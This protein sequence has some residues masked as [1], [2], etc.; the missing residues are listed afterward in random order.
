MTKMNAKI[1][2]KKSN[3][4]L[5]SVFCTGKCWETVSAFMNYQDCSE[6]NLRT[7]SGAGDHMLE[8]GVGR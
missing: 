5:R 1:E 3:Y 4:E 8:Q 2:M 6:P 7:G